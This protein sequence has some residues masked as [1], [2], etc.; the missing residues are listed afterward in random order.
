MCKG[1]DPC[2]YPN[3]CPNGGA[4]GHIEPVWGL[5]SNHPL[6]DPTVYDDDWVVHSSD[7]DLNPYYRKFSSLEDSTKMDG[8][9]AIAQ[10]GYGRNEM[11]PC[12]NDQVDYGLAI[13]GI[14]GEGLPTSLQVDSQD[15]PD[16]RRGELP[17]RMHGVV[18]VSG[19]NAGA[20]YVLYRYN[21]T[22]ALPTDGSVAGFE[23]RVPFTA[24]AE[25]WVYHVPAPIVSSSATYFRVFAASARAAQ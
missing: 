21:S 14:L 9:C 7:Q 18:T 5:F 17:I 16:I 25:T 13:T 22:A 24:T 11:Y 3:A 8:N 1:D 2:P 19:L 4:F 10:P 12:I 20:H 15:E 6:D 23:S